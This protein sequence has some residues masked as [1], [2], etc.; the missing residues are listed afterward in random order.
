[1]EH[2]TSSR[3]KKEFI[4]NLRK[5]LG[6]QC[7]GTKIEKKQT[8]TYYSGEGRSQLDENK[9]RCKIISQHTKNDKGVY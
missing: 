6:K 5:K 7:L 1:M 8:I 9:Y 2:I 4:K 3:V